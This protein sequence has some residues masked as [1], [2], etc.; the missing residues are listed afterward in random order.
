MQHHVLE[1]YVLYIEKK[2][3]NLTAFLE[4]FL[5]L[6]NNDSVEDV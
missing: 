5:Y 6:T 4:I 3:P 1:I 2:L